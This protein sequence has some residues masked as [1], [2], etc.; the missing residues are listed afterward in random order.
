M[1]ETKLVFLTNGTETTAH[2]PDTASRHV[3]TLPLP[4][5]LTP[6]ASQ[7]YLKD[8]KPYLIKEVRGDNDLMALTLG[9]DILQQHQ[10]FDPQGD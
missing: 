3:Y 7:T 10:T 5:N 8:E 1:N 2:P 4:E 9:D 6:N